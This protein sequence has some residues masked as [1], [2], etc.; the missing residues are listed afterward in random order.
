MESLRVECRKLS[1]IIRIHCDCVTIDC[2][3]GVVSVVLSEDI[4]V[5]D[6]DL[7]VLD[8]SL[9]IEVRKPPTSTHLF[10]DLHGAKHLHIHVPFHYELTFEEN[11]LE[12]L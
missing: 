1:H 2:G 5:E 3:V 11:Q 12:W 10:I 6:L 4:K 8:G 7:L 9:E